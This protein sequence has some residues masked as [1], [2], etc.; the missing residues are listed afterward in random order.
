[1]ILNCF[2]HLLYCLLFYL[3]PVGSSCLFQVDLTFLIHLQT[4]RIQAGEETAPHRFGLY[5]ACPGSSAAR[6][7]SRLRLDVP[8]F[9]H[10]V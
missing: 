10:L 4:V 9:K 7:P 3:W 6:A 8:D 2:G 5:P 1:M